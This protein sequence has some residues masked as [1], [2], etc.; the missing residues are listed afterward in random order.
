MYAIYKTNI[1]ACSCWTS[2]ENGLLSTESA[3]HWCQIHHRNTLATI[4]NPAV[5]LWAQGLVC[6][7]PWFPEYMLIM[8]GKK[9]N[10]FTLICFGF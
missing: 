1:F 3:K 6:F 9:I 2:V 5:Y 7:L 8:I 10:N 4:Y